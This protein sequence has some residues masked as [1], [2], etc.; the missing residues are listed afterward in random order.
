MEDGDGNLVVDQSHQRFLIPGALTAYLKHAVQSGGWCDHWKRIAAAETREDALALI[1]YL[2]TPLIDTDTY[3]SNALIDERIAHIKDYFYS[4]G[5]YCELSSSGYRGVSIEKNGGKFAV[6]IHINGKRKYISSYDTAIEAALAYDE[7][8]IE[9]NRPSLTLNFPDGLPINYIKPTPSNNSATGYR[10]VGKSGKKGRFR[11]MFYSDGKRK[12]LGT[13]D[14]A[15]QAALA[16]DQAA[17]KAGKKK[18]T[19]NFPDGLP[20]KQESDIDDGTAFWV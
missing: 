17:I 9:N 8:A 13:F 1:D 6:G 19:L 20:I 10:G 3:T 4:E 5:N 18:S 7:V 16:Y 2:G 11:A 14:T 15:I 12:S